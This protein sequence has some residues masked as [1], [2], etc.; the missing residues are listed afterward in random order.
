MIKSLRNRLE[1]TILRGLR[2][3]FWML[4]EQWEKEIRKERAVFREPIVIWDS[5]LR[6]AQDS[7]EEVQR[8][9]R[10]FQ[11]ICI[12]LNSSKSFSTPQKI[13]SIIEV[14]KDDNNIEAE[15]KESLELLIILRKE[16]K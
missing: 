4:E 14:L 16:K 11:D 3:S 9:N 13:R 6:T 7:Y 2:R 12:E 10:T 15:I 5:P 8:L 1:K